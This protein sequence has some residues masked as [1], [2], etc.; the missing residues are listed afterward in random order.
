MLYA[1]YYTYHMFLGIRVRDP[2]FFEQRA[3][4]HDRCTMRRVSFSMLKLRRS[5][6]R[7][8]ASGPDTWNSKRSA[9]RANPDETQQCI[10]DGSSTIYY[11]LYTMCCINYTMY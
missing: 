4:P 5:C 7:I 3:M 1:I 9:E 6:F 11:V 2:P 10:Y 8:G